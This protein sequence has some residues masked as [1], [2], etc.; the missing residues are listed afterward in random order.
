VVP[1]SNSITSGTNAQ[2]IAITNLAVGDSVTVSSNGTAKIVGDVIAASTLIDVR[3]LGAATLTKTVSSGTSLNFYV[4]DTKAD[5]LST[6]TVAVSETDGGTKATTTSTSYYE[7]SVGES[8]TVASVVVPSTLAQS[9]D[10]E[11]T[12]RVTDVFGNEVDATLATAN[13]ATPTLTVSTGSASGP[14]YSVSRKLWVGKITA[15]SNTRPYIVTIDGNGSATTPS[16]VGLGSS[17][18][19]NQLS[20]VNNTGVVSQITA[21]TGQVAALTADYNALVAKWNKL[22]ASKRAP[23]KKVALK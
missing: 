8:H 19:D 9:A 4:F 17:A 5:V 16:N 7:A 10:G 11:V 18:V 6:I 3:N 2:I 20:V 21:L 15:P 13:T 1:F 22:V 14:T 23:K 12:F